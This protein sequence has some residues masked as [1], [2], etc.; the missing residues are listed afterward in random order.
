MNPQLRQALIA[1]VAMILA[2]WTGLEI[3]DGNFFWPGLAA[4]IAIA[5]ILARVLRLPFDV[6]LTGMVL[7]GYLVGN[8][9][10]AQLA[11]APGVPLL[12]AE[13]ALGVALAWRTIAC[14]L[15]REWPAGR[16]WLGRL[17][18]AWLVVGGAR[19][20]LDLPRHG[21]M[22][23]RDFATVYY[24]LF[25]LLTVHMAADP[26]ARRFLLGSLV[27]GLL[28][29]PFSFALWLG[30]PDFFNTTLTVRGVPLI[31]F[32]GDLALT[33]LA[34]GALVLYFADAGRL[35]PWARLLSVGLVLVLAAND[36]RAS[37]LGFVVACGLLVAA[38]RWSFPATQALALAAALAAAAGLA[39]L[40]NNEWAQRK[41]HGVADRVRS[42]VDLTGQGT[43][44]SE[45]SSFKGDNNRFRAVWW[46][47]VILE[48]WHGN[49]VLGLGFGHDL[50]SGFLQEY[51]PDAGLEDFSA[52]S[53]HNIFVTV[54]GRMGALGLAVWGALCLALLRRTWQSLRR[55]ADPGA[56]ALWCGV[57]VIL[58]SASFGVVLEGPMGALPF[59]I[60]LGLA[61]TAD[62]PG[63]AAASV[64]LAAD[65]SSAVPL[66]PA[67]DAVHS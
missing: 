30:F 66:A 19:F 23:A 7:F 32:K 56:W 45:E 60:M 57:W 38:R 36:N 46:R 51:Y 18:L 24:A 53:P 26:R 48:T 49:P 13:L 65:P 15:R 50:A 10:F 2:A 17:V 20:A 25:Y 64:P 9:G 52:R 34:V 29:L 1:L 63:P 62:T 44:A 47:N 43:Y 42:V 27:A 37:L 54:W 12:P 28:V 16:G 39:F 58:V 59:W 22:A 5:A 61:D 67:P 35:R 21:I 41:L 4:S 33:F 11:P 8:R 31:F 55:G 3:A 14:A 6:I 40:G